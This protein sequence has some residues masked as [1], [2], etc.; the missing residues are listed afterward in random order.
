[1]TTPVALLAI[2]AAAGGLIGI[3]KVRAS[4]GNFV[5]A[6]AKPAGDADVFTGMAIT[7]V[8]ALLGVALAW[9]LHTGRVKA[10]NLGRA[11]ALLQ[12]GLR[13]DDAYAW[14]I[15]RALL[16]PAPLLGRFDEQAS[17][18]VLDE[19]GTGVA[20][21]AEAGRRWQL[22]RV[23]A[24]TMSAVAGVAVVAGAVVLGATGHLPWLGATR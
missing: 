16:R 3:P 22:G 15:E 9:T 18:A 6:G 17:H 11:T 21:A 7:A 19:L 8:V 5:F 13:I 24:I 1:M 14:V 12:H 2:L 23:D 20:T 10:P 4:F